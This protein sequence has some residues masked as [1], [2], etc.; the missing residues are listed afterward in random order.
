M[1]LTFVLTYKWTTVTFFWVSSSM[2][3]AVPDCVC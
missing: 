1:S 3:R 2:L